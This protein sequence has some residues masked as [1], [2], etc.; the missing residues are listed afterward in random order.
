MAI[1]T[2]KCF[3]SLTA[4]KYCQGTPVTPGEEGS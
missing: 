3:A 1:N 4:L 2:N